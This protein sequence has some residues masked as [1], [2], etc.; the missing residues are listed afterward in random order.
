V[1]WK[2]GPRDSAAAAPR[3]RYWVLPAGDSAPSGAR[4]LMALGPGV[5]VPVVNVWAGIG[6]SA[7]GILP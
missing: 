7:G 1:I 3:L 5:G 2:A 6:T 4:L